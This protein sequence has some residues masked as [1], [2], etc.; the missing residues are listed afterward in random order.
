ML[1]ELSLYP[2]GDTILT[3]GIRQF[4]AGERLNVCVIPASK[5][6]HSNG[7]IIQPLSSKMI[8]SP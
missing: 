7:K 3:D 8:L 2:A 5:K 1:N 4:L 6:L